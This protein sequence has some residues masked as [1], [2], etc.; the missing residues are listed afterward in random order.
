M[1]VLC[2]C[3]KNDLM[4]ALVCK[5]E[6]RLVTLYNVIFFKYDRHPV[7]VELHLP[8]TQECNNV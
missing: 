5:H 1:T 4:P 3:R 7:T 8:L 2:H 6:K